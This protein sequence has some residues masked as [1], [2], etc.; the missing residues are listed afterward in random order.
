MVTA[1][2]TTLALPAHTSGCTASERGA[3]GRIATAGEQ[4]ELIAFL[5]S[6]RASFITGGEYKADGG[7]MAALGVVLPE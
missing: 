5:A 3:L 7:M 6:P 1:P 2:A 4:A